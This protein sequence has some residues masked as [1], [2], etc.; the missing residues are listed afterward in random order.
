M[1]KITIRVPVIVWTLGDHEQSTDAGVTRVTRPLY[2]RPVGS[3]HLV[4]AG[5]INPDF[6]EP[7]MRVLSKV[8]RR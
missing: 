6:A 8:T 4:R 1:S 3:E 7:L 5:D 2:F